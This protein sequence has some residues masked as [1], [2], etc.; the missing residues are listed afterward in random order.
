MDRPFKSD[1][2]QIYYF[3][4]V[5]SLSANYRSYQIHDERRDRSNKNVGVVKM[6]IKDPPIAGLCGTLAIFCYGTDVVIKMLIMIS[7]VHDVRVVS[8]PERRHKI[9]RDIIL[10]AIYKPKSAKRHSAGAAHMNGLQGPF[11]TSRRFSA[12]RP[13]VF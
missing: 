11:N 12:R 9:E 2:S 6:R 4:C 8:G 1:G 13:A 3:F 10:I 7:F 5:F